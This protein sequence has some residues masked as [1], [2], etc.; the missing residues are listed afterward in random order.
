[1]MNFQCQRKRSKAISIFVGDEMEFVIE[2]ILEIIIEGT[3][4]VGT[5]KKVPL[6]IRIIA[7]LIFLLIYGALIGVIAMVGI[8]IWQDGNT[9]LSFMVFGIDIFIAMLVVCWIVKMYI[10]NYKNK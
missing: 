3:V 2:L 1:M 6:P 10:K 9:S 7:L 4:E 5:S 8:G